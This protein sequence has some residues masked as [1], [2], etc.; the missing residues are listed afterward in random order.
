M[1]RHL[2]APV[3]SVALAALFVAPLAAQE[4]TVERVDRLLID[5]VQQAEGRPLPT[6]GQ[7]MAQVEARFGAPQERRAPVGGDRPQHPPITRWIYADFSVYFE[8]DRVI[9]AV[10]NRA[11]PTERGP[12][13]VD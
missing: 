11:T 4:A 12:I 10:L 8:N 9:N 5:R 3:V 1:F 7:T 2:F 13:K 6:R